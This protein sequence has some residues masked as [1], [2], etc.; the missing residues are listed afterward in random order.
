MTARGVHDRTKQ[1]S[2]EEM[3]ELRKVFNSF[4]TDGDGTISV[5]EVCV[6][7]EKLGNK[8][9]REKVRDETIRLGASPGLWPPPH[10]AYCPFPPDCESS[11]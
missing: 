6:A 9:T 3:A 8:T 1:V 11:P 7:M 10:L 5:D 2:A 4:D